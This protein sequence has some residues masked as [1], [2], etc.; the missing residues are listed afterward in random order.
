MKKIY[1]FFDK[2]GA[3]C[4]DCS[5]CTR[6]G[7]GNKSCGAGMRHKRGGTGGCFCGTPMPEIRNRL[8]ASATDKNGAGK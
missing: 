5:E 1:S 3:L 2:R 8:E 6:G 4:V 7:N